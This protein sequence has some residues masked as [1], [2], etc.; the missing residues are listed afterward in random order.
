MKLSMSLLAHELSDSV[1]MLH[2]TDTACDISSVQV[3]SSESTAAVSKFVYLCRPSLLSDDFISQL[4]SMSCNI[5]IYGDID[6]ALKES[7]YSLNYFCLSEKQSMIS[8]FNRLQDIFLSY[9]RWD[10][11]LRSIPFSADFFQTFVD[12]AYEKIQI[13]MCI[14]DVNH[15]VIAI[16]RNV[17]N[18]DSLY[19]YMLNG[20]GYPCMN[21][22]RSSNPTLTE[23][24]KEGTQEVINNISH[25]RLRVTMIQ[26][27]TQTLCYIGLHREDDS[28]FP[29]AALQ[30]YDYIISILR[31]RATRLALYTPSKKNLF[32]QILLDLIDC[33]DKLSSNEDILEQLLDNF[34]Y[35]KVD[36]YRLYRIYSDSSLTKRLPNIIKFMEPIETTLPDT[37][38]FHRDEYIGILTRTTDYETWNSLFYSILNNYPVLCL[39]SGPFSDLLDIG[40]VEKQL[41][42]IARYLIGAEKHQIIAYDSYRIAHCT[43]EIQHEIPRETLYHPALRQLYEYDMKNHTEYLSTLICYLQNNCSVSAA[44][45]KLFIHRNSLQYRI[46]KIEEL[47]NMRERI[48]P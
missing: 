6:D 43:E 19:Q 14:L 24:D 34:H 17:D 38:C 23:L 26:N 7:L 4:I 31:E 46:K 16:N 35:K 13:P 48:V 41:N 32:E 42:Y 21:I 33:P 12:T 44:A 10:E 25:S 45:E 36:H 15:N 28:E 40:K 3:L 20:Y 37:V 47:L 5:I 29:V 18:P 30:L 8:Y 39:Q 2:L 11:R 9:S 1:V 27:R 22:I